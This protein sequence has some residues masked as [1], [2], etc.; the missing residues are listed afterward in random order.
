MKNDQS[1]DFSARLLAFYSTYVAAQT[2]AES[3]SLLEGLLE[4]RPRWELLPPAGAPIGV[5]AAEN[6]KGPI[7]AF[8][9]EARV[10]GVSSLGEALSLVTSRFAVARAIE[11]FG[12]STQKE[13]WVTPLVSGEKM[14]AYALTEPDAGSDATMVRTS[15]TLQ[16]QDWVLR[17]RK[18]VVVNAG[19][20]D[21]VL[22]FACGVGATEDERS[23][24]TAFVVPGAKKGMVTSPRPLA[25]LSGADAVDIVLDDV[26][27]GR[28]EV[29]GSPGSGLRIAQLVLDAVRLGTA[30]ALSGA[31]HAAYESVLARM[32]ER[33][34][35]EKRLVE[36]D[37]VVERLV[38]VAEELNALDATI[39][40]TAGLVE[41]GTEISAEAAALKLFAAESS[42]RISASLAELSGG[43]SAESP[44][45]ELCSAIMSLQSSGGAND[46]ARFFLALHGGRRVRDWLAA[47]K[48]ARRGAS[49]VDAAFKGWWR[50]VRLGLVRPRLPRVIA[51]SRGCLRAQSAGLT[52]AAGLWEECAGVTAERAHQ[53]FDYFGADA[54]DSEFHL[55]R[56]ADMATE[57]YVLLASLWYAPD[58]DDREMAFLGPPLRAR[59][60]WRRVAYASS[61]L[62]VGDAWDM[63]DYAKTLRNEAEAESE[64]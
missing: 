59:R 39:A 10:A 54:V 5:V 51:R 48:K 28:A 24:L 17:G 37:M 4:G 47:N 23:R 43:L 14:G 12:D 56:I 25:G 49:W 46:V 44:L 61:E 32:R 7:S 16:G 21:V 15:A 26:R 45:S 52:E 53:V 13:R 18:T 8:C 9:A 19:K 22:V 42:R 3:V 20:A 36:F 27:V 60:A 64:R 55:K 34:Q 1:F 6:V 58:A 57:T 33:R 63:E 62:F 50:G 35:F 30:A 31:L 11:A 40:L 2:R 29:L 41:R 38:F